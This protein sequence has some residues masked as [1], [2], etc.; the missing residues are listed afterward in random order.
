LRDVIIQTVP[1]VTTPQFRNMDQSA[2]QCMYYLCSGTFKGK[3]SHE[4]LAATR[5]KTCVIILACNHRE[6]QTIRALLH[7]PRRW[8]TRRQDFSLA[9]INKLIY[10]HH[11]S[12]ICTTIIFSLFSF[13]I[14]KKKKSYRTPSLTEMTSMIPSRSMNIW[15][16]VGNQAKTW[17]HEESRTSNRTLWLQANGKVSAML[18]W[19]R[20][21]QVR[22]NYIL[23]LSFCVKGGVPILCERRS[24]HFVWKKEY[25]FCVKGG[26]PILC[27]R[28]STHFVWKEEYPFCV[29][30]VPTLCERRRTHFVFK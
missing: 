19:L 7:N 28:R 3:H 8:E 13:W 26:V 12:S 1:A 21:L 20:D 18:R 22:S 16:P 29:K 15:T 30:G 25:P 17:W 4:I 6:K 5:I 24:T 14:A 10:H 23:F 27:E 2:F 9:S 11:T